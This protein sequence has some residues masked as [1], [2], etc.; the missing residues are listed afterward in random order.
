[1]KRRWRDT[2]F[3]VLLTC[4]FL[5]GGVAVLYAQGWRFDTSLLSFGKVGAIYLRTFPEETIVKIDGKELDKKPGIFDRG[6]FVNGLFPRSYTIETSAPGFRTWKT[7]VEVLPS[8]VEQLKHIVLVPNQ[9]SIVLSGPVE[10]LFGKNEVLITRDLSR[11]L[12]FKN[13]KLS[14]STV[15]GIS[16][17]GDA[18]L[19]HTPEQ[20]TY[21]WNDVETGTT[22]N[23]SV[24]FRDARNGFR[25]PANHSILMSEREDGTVLVSNTASLYLF[26]MRSNE[27]RPIVTRS[28]NPI[29]AFAISP[30]WISWSTYNAQKNISIVESYDRV[31]QQNTEDPVTLI[32]KTVS[33]AISGKE[34][35]GVLQHT[36]ELFLGVPRD[37][38][39]NIASDV[40]SF[41]FTDDGTKI[42][43]RE[44]Q[45]VEIFSLIE[46]EVMYARLNLPAGTDEEKLIW[47]HDNHHLFLTYNDRALFLDEIDKK[48]SSVIEIARGKDFFYNPE[49]NILYYIADGAVI[50]ME[51]PR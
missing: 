6:V 11:T 5:L 28:T 10:G 9:G 20:A 13:R 44:S 21:Y 26:T 39:R 29:T 23:L 15:L 8:L 4:F 41:L 1:M 51:F 35:L 14:G 17:V 45:A 30:R 32:G 19:T 38:L 33:L 25:I 22:S 47:Y 24:L 12:F 42:V 27:V 43:A 46:D 3:Y 36:G 49:E 7:D 40:R 50:G 34:T 48:L 31:A 18:V 2:L 37:P 16:N